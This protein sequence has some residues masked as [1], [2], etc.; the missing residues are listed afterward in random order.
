VNA[1]PRPHSAE[2]AVADLAY[3]IANVLNELADLHAQH[4]ELQA[5]YADL[6]AAGR[7]ALSAARDGEMNPLAYLADELATA[8]GQHDIDA[9][10]WAVDQ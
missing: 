5:R 10:R 6:I 2:L 1:I 9:P 3:A 7:A 4:T 8:H